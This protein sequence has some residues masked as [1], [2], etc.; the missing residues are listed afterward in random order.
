MII[1]AVMIFGLLSA[2][3]EAIILLKLSPR[4]RLRLL[5]SGTAIAV[6]HSFA[7][8]FNLA[9]HYGTVTGTMTAIV[10][11]IASFLVIPLLRSYCGCIRTITMTD[12][13]SEQRYFPGMKRYPHTVLQ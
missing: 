3:F 6:V 9:V 11:G 5:G 10:A 7:I 13:S 8:L 2:L 12:G 1:D 4:L